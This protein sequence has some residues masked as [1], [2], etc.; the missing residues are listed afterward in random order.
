MQCPVPVNSFYRALGTLLMV[1]RGAFLDHLETEVAS[2]LHGAQGSD[3]RDNPAC[4]SI[5]A[6]AL[7]GVSRL[8]ND[9]GLSARLLA[10]TGG[11]IVTATRAILNRW[12]RLAR[13]LG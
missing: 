6:R 11:A 3:V 1:A 12:T 8:P 9:A 4:I 7:G 2:L 13:A 5:P 10:P